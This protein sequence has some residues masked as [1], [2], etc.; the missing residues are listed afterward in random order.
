MEV[1]AAGWPQRASTM[2]VVGNALLFS[3]V[4]LARFSS[5]QRCCVC[6]RVDTDFFSLVTEER[7]TNF[8]VN[9][10]FILIFISSKIPR[11]FFFGSLGVVWSQG[12][13]LIRPFLSLTAALV[14]P[15]DERVNFSNL[16]ISFPS[17]SLHLF[18]LCFLMYVIVHVSFCITEINREV[19]FFLPGTSTRETFR[20]SL[21]FQKIKTSF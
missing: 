4:F 7:R 16:F 17:L 10:I 19:C 6:K 9:L 20:R 11:L 13:G 21:C 15:N 8:G 14:S 1:V 3:S 12:V 18:W 2:D 5:E